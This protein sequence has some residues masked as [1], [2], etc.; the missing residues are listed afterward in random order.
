[1][2]FDFRT[3]LKARNNF[4]YCYY[5]NYKEFVWQLLQVRKLAK[6]A[7]PDINVFISCTSEIAQSISQEGVISA[8]EFKKQ[9]FLKTEEL[10]FNMQENPVLKVF[11]DSSMI[12]NH[13]P[14][15][16]KSTC[17]INTNSKI[18]FKS[19]DKSIV[20]S[21]LQKS[22]LLTDNEEEADVV[23][24]TENES[25]YKA[26]YLG[27]HTILVGESEVYKKLFPANEI[28]IM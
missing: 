16:D 23:C 18:P 28:L 9:L 15:Y 24:A 12:S 17:F 10:T 1:M 5:G 27:K 19:Y 11:N 8:D 26:A 14:A 3:Y 4:C 21:R 25:L 6:Q 22:Y 20:I 2:A 7:F 13:I